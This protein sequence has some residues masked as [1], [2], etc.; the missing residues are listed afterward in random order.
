MLYDNINTGDNVEISL[1]LENGKSSKSYISKV[2]TVV[3]KDEILIQVPYSKGQLIKLPISDRYSM[4]FST[5]NGMFRFDTAITGYT[6][7]ENFRYISCSLLSEGRKV[8]RRQYFRYNCDLDFKLYKYIN[9]RLAREKLLEGR[10]V[11]IGGGGIK[12]YSNTDIDVEDTIQTVLVLNNEFVIVDT[13]ILAKFNI[14]PEKGNYRYQYRAEFKD[15]SEADREKIIQF[16]FNEQR[17]NLR[18]GSQ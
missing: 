1:K 12:F 8:Q 14:D 17:R 9:E 3:S 10:L 16:I 13:K 2:E 11:D 5:K 7:I 6:S 18:R 4:L 15:I